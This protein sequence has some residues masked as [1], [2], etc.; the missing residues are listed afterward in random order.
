MQLPNL[1]IC[2]IK[3]RLE[4]IISMHLT[5]AIIKIIAV[6]ERIKILPHKNHNQLQCELSSQDQTTILYFFHC[7]CYLI[8]LRKKKIIKTRKMSRDRK[9]V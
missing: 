2:R 5:R 4:A 9:L 3:G 7:Y 1:T 6:Y 8:N